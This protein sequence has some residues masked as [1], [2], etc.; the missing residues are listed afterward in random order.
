MSRNSKFAS[1]GR[2]PPFAGDGTVRLVPGTVTGPFP[3]LN[4]T[5]AR[6]EVVGVPSSNQNEEEEVGRKSEQGAIVPGQEVS[7]RSRDNRK[8]EATTQDT[9]V[10]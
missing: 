4:P 10:A 8:G 9:Q 6:Y 7:W 2:A 3:F 5:R 1:P